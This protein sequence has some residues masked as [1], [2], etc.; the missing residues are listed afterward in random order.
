MSSDR[1]LR[2][3]IFP[4]PLEQLDESLGLDPPADLIRQL[5]T[6]SIKHVLGVFVAGGLV[7]EVLLE[8]EMDVHGLL[9]VNF[10]GISRLEANYSW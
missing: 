6:S 3:S 9:S 1:I 5:K 4:R 8:Q 2:R 7:S 10:Q